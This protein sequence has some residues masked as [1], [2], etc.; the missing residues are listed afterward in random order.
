M[1]G[2]KISCLKIAGNLGRRE[3]KEEEERREGLAAACL[4]YKL[5]GSK[6]RKRP[7]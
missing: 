6:E 2:D 7:N 4:V 5:W 1:V 3:E